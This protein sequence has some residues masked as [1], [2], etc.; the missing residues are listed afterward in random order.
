[1]RPDCSTIGAFNI[2]LK[3]T[4]LESAPRLA[5]DPRIVLN[6]WGWISEMRISIGS[7]SSR[8]AGSCSRYWLAFF[9][10]H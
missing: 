2:H 6:R 8:C 9:Y 7:R 3:L 1:M 4:L 5:P 10:Q